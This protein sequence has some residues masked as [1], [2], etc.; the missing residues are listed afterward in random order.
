MNTG[1]SLPGG[2]GHS[3][4]GPQFPNTAIV[5]PPV[6][7]MGPSDPIHLSAAEIYR[8]KHEVTASVCVLMNQTLL[9]P[10]KRIQLCGMMHATLGVT[11]CSL[12]N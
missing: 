4:G 5:R 3:P 12:V 10:T 8:Q 6:A 11:I 1:P 2:F 7:M 9:Y